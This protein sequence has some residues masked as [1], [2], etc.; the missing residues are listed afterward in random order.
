MVACACLIF[1][2]S[3]VASRALEPGEVWVK[4]FDGPADLYDSAQA[5]AVSPDGTAVFVTGEIATGSTFSYE[6]DFGTIAYDFD[7]R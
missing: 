5:L 1:S 4:R 7:R 6:P 2:L 3:T